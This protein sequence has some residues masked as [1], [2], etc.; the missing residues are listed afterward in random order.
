M[1]Q[2]KILKWASGS[3]LENTLSE[4]ACMHDLKPRREGGYTV[5]QYRAVDQLKAHKGMLG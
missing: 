3:E 2:T 4:V 1:K 5:T